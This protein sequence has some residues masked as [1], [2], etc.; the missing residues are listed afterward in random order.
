[1]INHFNVI[2]YVIKPLTTIKINKIFDDSI[3]VWL[4]TGF[5]DK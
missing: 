2:L 4:V 3:L 5:S 1:M